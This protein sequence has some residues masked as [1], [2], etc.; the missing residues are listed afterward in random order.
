MRD[1]RSGLVFND[2]RSRHARRARFEFADA[3]DQISDG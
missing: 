2:R 1:R 3:L